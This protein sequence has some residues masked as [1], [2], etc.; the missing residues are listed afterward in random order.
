MSKVTPIRA[1]NQDA[2]APLPPHDITITVN[3]SGERQIIVR[4]PVTEAISRDEANRRTDALMAVAERQRS[5]IEIRVLT[6]DLASKRAALTDVWQKRKAEAEEKH[7]VALK[8]IENTIVDTE[9]RRTELVEGF[10]KTERDRGK[11][12]DIQLVGNVKNRE[13]RMQ[14]DIAAQ[15]AKVKTLEA[16]HLQNIQVIDG[17]IEKLTNE[18]AAMERLLQKHQ[19][20]VG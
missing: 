18:I 7:A 20:L 13:A 8:T 16:E 1:A 4:S 11:T 6:E 17:N 10:I 15:R 14:Q 12:G 5:I 3:L 19:E 2:P 9:T